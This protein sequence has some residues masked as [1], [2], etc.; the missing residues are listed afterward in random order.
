MKKGIL[1]SIVFFIPAVVLGQVTVIDTIWI[2]PQ[3]GNGQGC[4]EVAV[5]PTTNRIYV[6]NGNVSVIDGAV[7]SV[8]ATIDVGEIPRGIGVNPITNRIYVASGNVV[9]IEYIE[10]F[11]NNR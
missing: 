10:H 6:S 5:N 3:A 8:I 4:R 11:G 7:D 1:L 9:V 2:A